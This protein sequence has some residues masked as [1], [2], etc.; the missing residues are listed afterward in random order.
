MGMIVTRLKETTCHSIAMSVLLLNLRRIEKLR[1]EIL[2][3]FAC[4]L[5][6]G[7]VQ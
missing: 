7:F 6:F 3:L 1:A 5:K 2:L 4:S